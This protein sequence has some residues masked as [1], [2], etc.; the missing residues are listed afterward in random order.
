[1]LVR[2][3]RFRFVQPSVKVLTS[4]RIL[5]HVGVSN[6]QLIKEGVPISA[7]YNQRS[8]A[9]QNSLDLSWDLLMEDRYSDLR[10]Y[11]FSTREDLLRFRQLVVNVSTLDMPNHGSTCFRVGPYFTLFS[12]ISRSWQ[13]ISSTRS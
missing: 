8:V 3:L 9:E 10:N 11:L 12:S 7:K 13:R 6:A 4:T 1:M 5:D 2:D